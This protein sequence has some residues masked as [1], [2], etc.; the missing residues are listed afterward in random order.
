MADTQQLTPEQYELF[1]N[2]EKRLKQKRLLYIHF[3]VMV[4]GCIFFAI[5]GIFGRALFGF[6][7]GYGTQ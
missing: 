2:A 4:L 7:F 5:I 1:K 6:S 3:F